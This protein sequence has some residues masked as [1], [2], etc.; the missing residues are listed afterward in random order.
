MDYAQLADHV[1]E[2]FSLA[3][4]PVTLTTGRACQVIFS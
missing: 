2:V 3:G 1:G 4:V